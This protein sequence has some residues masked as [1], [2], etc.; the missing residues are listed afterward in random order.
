MA[1][2]KI[3][4]FIDTD[5]ISYEELMLDEDPYETYLREEKVKGMLTEEN[6]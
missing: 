3:T 1:E 5:T 2:D 6:A 4:I